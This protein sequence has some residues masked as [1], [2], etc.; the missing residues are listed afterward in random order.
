[1]TAAEAEAILEKTFP[2]FAN[3]PHLLEVNIAKHC[4]EDWHLDVLTGMIA[5]SDLSIAS[6]RCPTTQ[7][8]WLS[9]LDRP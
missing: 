3:I 5:P 8:S 4:I 6:P 2:K 9:S 1:M 7:T